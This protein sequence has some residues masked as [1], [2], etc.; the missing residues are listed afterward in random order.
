MG[1]VEQMTQPV[2]TVGEDVLEQARQE[3]ARVKRA[4]KVGQDVMSDETLRA[5]LTKEA[6]LLT[7]IAK[8]E[9]A[10]ND[11]DRRAR[12]QKQAKDDIDHACDKWGGWTVD[13][14]RQFLRLVTDSITLEEL[15]PGWLRL[16][17]VWS[18]LM[19]FVSPVTSTTRAVDTL[20]LWRK[21]GREWSDDEIA[22]LREHYPTASRNDLLHLF[23]SRSWF[24]I[25]QK[26]SK[27][28]IRR[29][30]GS[31][32]LS[33]PI[34]MSLSDLHIVKEFAIE[35]GKRV[36]WQHEYTHAQLTNDVTQS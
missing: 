11:G 33:I 27:S 3:L 17:I 12:Q 14:R 22:R 32:A 20:Y 34:D 31:D 10:Q 8:L 19:G 30:V 24:G 6:N 18:P 26:A 16:V 15:A 35:P 29:T 21:A 36:Q 4:L 23:P 9:Q 2:T 1:T 5:H 7:R 13:E 28:G 25:T